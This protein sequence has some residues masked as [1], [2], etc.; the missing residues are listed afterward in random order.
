MRLSATPCPGRMVGC[1]SASSAAF[2][3]RKDTKAIE[4]LSRYLSDADPTV[5]EAAARTLGSL[6]GPAAPALRKALATG[7][8]ANLAAV[9]EGLFRCAETLSGTEAA[10][11]YDTVRT[12]KTLP[13]HVHERRVVG[14]IRSRGRAECRCC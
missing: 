5:A 12:L 10:A 14:A 8:P 1:S 9:C 6:G 3:V 4:P 7:P 2:G 11:I 13:P